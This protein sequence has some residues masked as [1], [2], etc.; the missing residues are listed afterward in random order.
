MKTKILLILFTFSVLTTFSQNKKVID[1]WKNG[2]R[3]REGTLSAG[4]EHGTWT[5]YNENGSLNQV[6]N[7]HRG[8]LHGNTIFYYANG[9]KET[10]TEFYNNYQEGSFKEWYPNGILRIS[11]YYWDGKKDSIWNTFYPTGDLLKTEV[12]KGDTILLVEGFN[13]DSSLNMPRIVAI[14]I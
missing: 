8:R 4:Q 13:Q 6:V 10:E 1:F 9:K 11:G 3:K 5:Y 7:Y 2:K 14:Y 12:I